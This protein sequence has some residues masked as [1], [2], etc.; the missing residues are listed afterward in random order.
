MALSWEIDAA[1]RD[2][3]AAKPTSGRGVNN[4]VGDVRDL[5]PEEKHWAGVQARNYTLDHHGEDVQVF[6]ELLDALG[7][8]HDMTTEEAP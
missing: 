1:A 2:A 5:T 8:D 7:I 4:S 3:T 6:T